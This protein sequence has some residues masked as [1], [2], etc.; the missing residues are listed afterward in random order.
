MSCMAIT[1]K[2]MW[3][4]ENKHLEIQENLDISNKDA[5]SNLVLSSLDLNWLELVVRKYSQGA[6]ECAY[7]SRSYLGHSP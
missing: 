6:S 3:T 5:T 7:A 2:V 1:L 4:S